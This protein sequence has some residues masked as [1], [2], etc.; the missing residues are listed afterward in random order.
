MDKNEKYFFDEPITLSKV[1]EFVVYLQ[2]LESDNEWLPSPHSI[3]PYLDFMEQ[4]VA[5]QG[6]IADFYE[7]EDTLGDFHRDAYEQ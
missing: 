1:R 4:E 7:L 6:Y 3:K 5:E 2:K